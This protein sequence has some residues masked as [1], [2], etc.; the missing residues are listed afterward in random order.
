MI[1]VM[2]GASLVCAGL[3]LVFRAREGAALVLE[4]WKRP[5]CAIKDIQPGVVELAG[6]LSA[7]DGP[8]EGLSRKGAV[9]VKTTLTGFRGEGRRR[10]RLGERNVVRAARAVLRDESGACVVDLEDAEIVGEEWT[11][12]VA[13]VSGLPA[14]WPSWAR[15]LVP[16]EA[17]RVKVDEV[18][19][20]DG[21]EVMVTAVTR[22][23]ERTEGF[24]RDAQSRWEVGGDET[25]KVLVTVGGQGKLFRR[26]GGAVAFAVL[27]GVLLVVQGVATIWAGVTLR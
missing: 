24:Y 11:S 5:T 9:A 2:L 18:V 10:E 16:P 7:S 19:V 4:V 17:S 1:V 27:C 21:A 26:T 12:S 22:R 8:I 6:T 25:R 13:P 23:Q 20:P 3:A 14:E 15:D